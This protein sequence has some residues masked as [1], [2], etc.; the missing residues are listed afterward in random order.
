MAKIKEEE[1]EKL[2]SS[3]KNNKEYSYEEL[4]NKYSKLVYKIAFSILKNEDDAEDVMQIVFAKI[5]NLD[6]SKLPTRKQSSW[7]YTVT[8]N[9]AII[10]LKKKS[11]YIE[12]E[13][14]YEIPK[15]NNEIDKIIDKEYFN[16]IIDKLNKKEKEIVTLK[17]IS[18]LSFDDISKIIDEPIGTVKW[19]YYKSINNLKLIL[20]NLG[21]FI[22]TFVI[23]LKTL[24]SKNKVQEEI[25]K[26]ESLQQNNEETENNRESIEQTKGEAKKNEI[27]SE[28]TEEKEIL[29]DDTNSF[30][31]KIDENVKQESIM[32][33]KAEQGTNYCAIGILSVSV[34]FLIVTIIFLI[35]YQLKGKKKTSK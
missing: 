18:D 26:S 11:K 19:R 8:K 2:F 14:V 31:E 16:K 12:L 5:Y 32:Q 22:I 7:L 15:E 17:V 23:G 27:Q 21:M 3:I 6:K 24:F 9:E 29:L 34:I 4:Y 13:D 30:N 10:Y 33:D 25:T 1:L 35:K 28:A 20:G